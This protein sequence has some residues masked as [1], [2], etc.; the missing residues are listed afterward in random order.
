M[1]NMIP[2]IF[3]SEES[4]LFAGYVLKDTDFTQR[5]FTDV[6]RCRPIIRQR[7]GNGVSGFASDGPSSNCKMGS[8]CDMPVIHRVVN[9]YR[10]SEVA[11]KAIWNEG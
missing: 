6:K 8:E 3:Q 7:T 1:E 9:V 11:E 2:V 4:F 5:T 10:I